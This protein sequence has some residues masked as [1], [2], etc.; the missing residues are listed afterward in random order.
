[1]YLINAY[2]ILSGW[3]HNEN[4]TEEDKKQIE[5][6]IA[7]I[8]LFGSKKMINVLNNFIDNYN[9]GGDVTKLLDTLVAELRS[10]LKMEQLDSRR[11]FFCFK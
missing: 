4:L 6:V 1:M 10:E 9:K 5:R 11:R 3:V 7:D 8:Q 2:R